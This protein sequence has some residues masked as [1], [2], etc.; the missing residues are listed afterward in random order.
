MY[1]SN[2]FSSTV[3]VRFQEQPSTMRSE[4]ANVFLR[5]GKTWDPRMY[6]SQDEPMVGFFDETKMLQKHA[7]AELQWLEH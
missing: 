6:G 3:P 5:G 1:F 7:T 4:D 2:K